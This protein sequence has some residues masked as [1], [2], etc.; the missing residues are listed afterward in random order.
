MKTLLI[1]LAVLVCMAIPTTARVALAAPAGAA[2]EQARAQLERGHYA[3]AHRR[4]A[5]LADCGH[6][7]AAR[8]ALEMRQFGPQ[9][10]R[11]NFQV[12]PKQLTRWRALLAAPATLPTQ[13]G[14]HSGLACEAPPPAG[15]ASDE[16]EY[17]RHQGVG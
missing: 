10:Y 11:M 5:Q 12:G 6:R 13:A 2:F 9:L 1:P 16:Q 3:E 4:F 15:S 7:E 17:W 8:I 14:S